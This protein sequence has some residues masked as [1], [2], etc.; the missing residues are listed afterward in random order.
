MKQ[1]SI[2]IVH[3]SALIDKIFHV[4]L[5]M[6]LVFQ[7]VGWSMQDH[8]IV[9]KHSRS[10]FVATTTI[11]GSSSGREALQDED[12]HLPSKKPTD[13]HKTELAAPAFVMPPTDV[14]AR[15]H[16]TKVSTELI[17]KQHQAGHHLN[18]VVE[19]KTVRENNETLR[20]HSIFSSQDQLADLQRDSSLDENASAEKLWQIETSWWRGTLRWANADSFL[21]RLGYFLVLRNDEVTLTD[22]K[23]KGCSRP[24]WLSG[25]SFSVESDSARKRALFIDGLRQGAEFV[26]FRTLHTGITALAIYQLW[27][28]LHKRTKIPIGFI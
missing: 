8:N 26:I 7:N 2:W 5:A 22:D 23:K 24:V 27:V 19:M 28:A 15:D 14:N 16:E 11:P 12:D 10:S 6:L 9:E 21:Q 3:F 20:S 13:E 17:K 1:K 4:M 25:G 18:D